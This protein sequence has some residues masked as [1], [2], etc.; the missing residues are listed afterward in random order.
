MSEPLRTVAEIAELL[1]F[2]AG[3][4]LDWFESG[5]LPG[6]KVGRA[7]RF[8]ESEVLA[9]LEAQRMG[10]GGG[11]NASYTTPPPR[12]VV[13]GLPATSKEDLHAS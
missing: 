3:T 7:V 5:R 10:D 12:G 11:C 6:F 2:T 13:Y 4:I 9:W 1:G 8:R